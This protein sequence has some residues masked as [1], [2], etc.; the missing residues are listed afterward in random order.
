MF[1]S[2]KTLFK[3]VDMLLRLGLLLVLGYFL[4]ACSIIPDLP[5]P[6]GIPG[7]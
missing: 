2:L 3:A 4:L 5:G 7:V 6:I 1:A